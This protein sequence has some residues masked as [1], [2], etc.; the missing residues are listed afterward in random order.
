MPTLEN[1]F[2]I[3]KVHLI[4]DAPSITELIAKVMSEMR[5]TLDGI[6]GR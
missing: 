4:S 6:Y 5:N 1:F 2:R 3:L